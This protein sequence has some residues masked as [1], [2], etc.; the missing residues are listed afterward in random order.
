MKKS[1][2]TSTVLWSV[3]QTGARQQ[4]AG[5]FQ[6]STP[7]EKLIWCH[8]KMTDPENYQHEL[9]RHSRVDYRGRQNILKLSSV[10]VQWRR[11]EF[12]SGR[13]RFGI[14]KRPKIITV[15]RT[16][17][18]SNLYSRV[19]VIVLGLSVIQ[20]QCTIIKIRKLKKYWCINKLSWCWQT[21]V[22]RLDKVTKHCTIRCVRY[23]FLLVSYSK[24][25]RKTQNIS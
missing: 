22:T 4:N 25:V 7:N 5:S 15:Y 8:Q 12:V 18:G 21:R 14:V 23:G 19:C 24:F 3:N 11:Q 6:E 17:L 10:G 13:H 20:I 2:E 1:L 16:T 9:C